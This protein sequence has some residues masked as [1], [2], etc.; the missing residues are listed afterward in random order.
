MK[1]AKVLLTLF[2]VVES[3]R[4]TELDDASLKSG[5][6]P[7][8]ILEKIPTMSN[9]RERRSVMRKLAKRHEELNADDVA[10]IVAIVGG[11]ES[12][13]VRRAAAGA[14]GR[15]GVDKIGTAGLDAL[16][17]CLSGDKHAPARRDCSFQFGRLGE[18]AGSVESLKKAMGDENPEVRRESVVSLGKIAFKSGTAVVEGAVAQIAEAMQNDDDVSVRR[19]AAVAIGVMKNPVTS[20]QLD[21]LIEVAEKADEHLSVRREAIRAMIYLQGDSAAVAKAGDALKKIVEDEDAPQEVQDAA[22]AILKRLR[23]IHK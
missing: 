15:M 2:A 21:D 20:G 16:K 3:A 14:L 10:S 8:D 13:D 22:K 5:G 11:D 9:P 19:E 1:L 18:Y 6:E 7:Q 12:G 23:I 17:D 4:R